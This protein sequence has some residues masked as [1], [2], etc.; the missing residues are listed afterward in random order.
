MATMSPSNQ[1]FSICAVE[2]I[3]PAAYHL[4]ELLEALP[5]VVDVELVGM[6][7]NVE[8]LRLVGL[9]A[10]ELLAETKHLVHLSVV[11]DGGVEE[12]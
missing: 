3:F 9:E 11:V 1:T 12:V 6:A 5:I 2:Y 10:Q 7:P 8:Q 4:E